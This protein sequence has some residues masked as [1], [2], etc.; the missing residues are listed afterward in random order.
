MNNAY[1]VGT[2]STIFFLQN[3]H[4]CYLIVNYYKRIDFI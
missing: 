1:F 2:Y 4:N 3:L